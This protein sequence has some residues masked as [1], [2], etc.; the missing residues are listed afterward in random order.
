MIDVSYRYRK[1]DL[2]GGRMMMD[3]ETGTIRLEGVTD[4]EWMSVPIDEYVEMPLPKDFGMTIKQEEELAQGAKP[5]APTKKAKPH[6][7]A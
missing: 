6:V 4:P 5:T 3:P 1:D 2:H 7:K